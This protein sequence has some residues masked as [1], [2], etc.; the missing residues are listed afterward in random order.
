MRVSIVALALGVFAATARAATLE[1]MTSVASSGTQLTTIITVDEYTLTLTAPSAISYKSR[2]YFP[3][4][5]TPGDKTDIMA[6]GPT[7]RFKAGDTVNVTL[8]NQLNANPVRER[9][10]VLSA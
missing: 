1:A 3:A 2:G 9:T 10:S 5:V 6:V 4:G 7:L 8:N